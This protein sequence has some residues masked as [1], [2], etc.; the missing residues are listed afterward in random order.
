MCILYLLVYHFTRFR[1]AEKHTP[2][3]H[4][5]CVMARYLTRNPKKD[6]AWFN[7]LVYQL[8]TVTVNLVGDWVLTAY[9]GGYHPR[10]KIHL[11]EYSVILTTSF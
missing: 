10:L 1:C 11:E 9:L 4:Y 8:I 6:K 5:R 3:N 2:Q 7:K